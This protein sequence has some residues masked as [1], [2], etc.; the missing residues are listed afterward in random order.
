MLNSDNPFK[1][2]TQ[3][4]VAM[5]LPYQSNPQIEKLLYST[6]KKKENQQKHVYIPRE[7][8]GKIA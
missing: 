6:T 8:D 7:I 4:D 3:K 1:K 5:T 2:E